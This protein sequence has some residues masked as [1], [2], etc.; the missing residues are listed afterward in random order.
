[1]LQIALALTLGYLM[2]KLVLLHRFS[3]FHGAQVERRDEEL[4]DLLEFQRND[5]EKLRQ[6]VQAGRVDDGAQVI[7][8][9]GRWGEG[10]SF[11]I[12]R[13][14]T[15]MKRRATEEK[16]PRDSC[17]VVR[18]NVWEEQ[19][20]PD[21]HL[22]I[23]EQILGHKRYWYPYGWLRYPL[24]LYLAR[25]AKE[26]RLA[27]SAGTQAKA[28]LELPVRLPRPTGKLTLERLAARVRNKGC[29]TVVVLDEIDRAASPIAQA[30]V[31]LAVRS[32]NL[33]G[34]V[35]VLA[36]VEEILR[37]KAFNP[38]VDCLPD[39]GS[40]MRAVVFASGPD[41]GDSG[42]PGGGI[43]TAGPSSLARWKAWLDAANVSLPNGDS[44]LAVVGDAG[45][46]QTADQ[47]S[48][49]LSDAVRLGFAYADRNQRQR[50]QSRFAEKY[51]G[52]HPIQLQ[53][54]KVGDVAHMVVKF[55]R[56]AHWVS[57]LVGDDEGLPGDPANPSGS[58]GG[59]MQDRVDKAIQDAFSYYQPNVS[60]IPPIRSLEGELFRRLSGI[61]L[62]EA[63]LTRISPQFVAAVTLAA[64]DAATLQNL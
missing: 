53:H 29:R 45:Q 64:F 31:T 32:L 60:T 50:L 3:A 28:K 25:L 43:D 48:R 59:K 52:S 13:F 27:I 9:V 38:L 7:Q 22:A 5:L 23:V 16:T 56:L 61:H 57:E 19:S 44:G 41:Q 1:M 39:L 8:L 62:E 14:S 35:V 6:A 12:E 2:S 10:K 47:D 36:Y 42:T 15:Y 63:G 18:V 20:E 49:R 46:R 26:A 34:M 24:S 51:L 40:T 58:A 17:A 30:A 33:P 11:L 55:D 54:L 4:E 21:L 37:Y